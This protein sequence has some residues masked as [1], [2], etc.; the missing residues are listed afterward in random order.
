MTSR[1]LV[2]DAIVLHAFDY[3]E[4]SR[5]LRLATRE[6]GVQSVIAR[7]ARRSSRR[8][9]SALDL[10]A[11]GVAE[12][13]LRANRDLQ[14]LNTFEVTVARPALAADLDRFGAAAMLSELVLRAAGAGENAELFTRFAHHLD[15]LVIL[16]GAEAR[17]YSIGAAW[18]VIAELGFAPAVDD[19]AGCHAEVPIELPA[20]FSHSA[21]GV[22]CD[23]CARSGK[24]ARELPASAR[25]AISTWLRGDT[26]AVDDPLTARAH[27]RLLRE[28]VERHVTE[29]TQMKAF[30]AWAR[31]FHQAAASD[32][33]R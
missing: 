14:Q 8:F 29:G 27:V 23:N 5:I 30:D 22:L 2:S 13:H 3:L 17:A 31:R 15:Q 20:P 6:H 18:T 7:G 9:G 12:L 16:G 25:L 11:S 19:C 33:V 26:V 10:F 28:F 32:G 21:G 1:V 4:T 24:A